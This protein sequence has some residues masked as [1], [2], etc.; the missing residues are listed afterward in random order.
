[1]NWLK[2]VIL[3]MLLIIVSELKKLTT[4]QKS[5]ILQIKYLTMINVLLLMILINFQTQNLI[6]IKK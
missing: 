5:I 6:K 3:L 1:M 4:T 2:K